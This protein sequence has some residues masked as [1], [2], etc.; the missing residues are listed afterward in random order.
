MAMKDAKGLVD[1]WLDAIESRNAERITE[2]LADD[3]SMETEALREP[4]KGKQLLHML[5]A[6]AMD[7]Y[8]S[9]RIDRR[10]VIAAGRD[11]A[12]LVDVRVRFGSDVEMLGEKLPTAGKSL[13]IVAAVFIEV[14]DAGKIA[15]LVRVRDNLAVVD[16][17]GLTLER[18]KELTGKL[19]TQMAERRSRAA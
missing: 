5:L 8:E 14:N 2:L 10:K 13:D 6:G 17:L 3:V 12:M 7:A 11:V 18:V 1:E 9:I 15:R 4:I 16:Q 19:E